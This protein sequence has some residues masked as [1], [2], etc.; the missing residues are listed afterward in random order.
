MSNVVAH[1]TAA[2][3]T[4]PLLAFF[5]VYF[6]ARKW[7]RKKK[8]SFYVAINVSTFFFI[9]AVHFFIVAI[10]GKSYFPVMLISLLLLH[11]V[12]VIGYWKKKGDIHIPTIFRLFWRFSFLL[13]FFL[14]VG[15]L[16]YGIFVRVT[17]L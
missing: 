9:V 1:I 5:V 10:W 7:T 8:K 13:F 2:F 6:I 17:N 11:L 4:V 12:F 16:S 3:V 14:Y 15:L